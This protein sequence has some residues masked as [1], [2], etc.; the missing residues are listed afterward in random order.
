MIRKVRPDWKK[1]DIILQK[2]NQGFSNILFGGYTSKKEEMIL[3]KIYGNTNVNKVIS[4][5]LLIYQIFVYLFICLFVYL[6]V[7][8]QQRELDALR[9]F[10][11]RRF[12]SQVYAV[13]ANGYVYEYAPGVPLNYE[14][15][16]DVNIYPIVAQKIGRL[17]KS[18]AG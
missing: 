8:L 2:F 12:G 3:V 1:E 5:N 14:L 17:H 10:A 6:F 4:T 16:I 13:F 7:C 11:A 9:L 15:C 18:L